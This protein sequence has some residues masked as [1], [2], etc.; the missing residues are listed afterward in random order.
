MDST[1]HQKI[2]EHLSKSQQVGVVVNRN[3]NLDA[4]AAALGLYLSLKQAGKNVV[5]VSPTDPIVE[6]SNL[7]G[8]DKVKKSLGGEGG[9]LTISFPYREGE[10]EKVSYNIDEQSGHFNLV[11]KAGN[12]GLT[13]EEKEV[14]FKRGGKSLHMLF[15][16]GVP[17]L[18]EV[19]DV[20]SS[21]IH[22][23]AVVVN[24]DNKQNN[25][26]FGDVV[27]VFPQSSSL[28][29]QIADFLTLPDTN[30]QVDTDIAQNLLS[31]ITYATN[32]FQDPKTSHLAF[33]MAGILMRRGAVRYARAHTVEER[34]QS[35]AYTPQQPQSQPVNQQ[36][37]PQQVQPQHMPVQQPRPQ[38][39]YPTQQP[40]QQFTMQQAPQPQRMQSAQPSRVQLSEPPQNAQPAS[41]DRQPPAD[42]LQPKVYKGSSFS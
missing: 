24:I 37:R 39:S 15:L 19:S 10:V 34:K 11:I 13:F 31:G 1:I 21:D 20:L 36:P 9:D 17:S 5:I 29:E 2:K 26:Q 25:Q 30:M 8:I 12:K 7:V 33:E 14:L 18:S 23:N 40:R 28:S 41:P 32:D 42:W 27:A 22:K 16:I 35:Q 6:I 4:M 3:P 38:Q